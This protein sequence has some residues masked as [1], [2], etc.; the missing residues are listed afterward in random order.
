MSAFTF[1][2]L[3]PT[4]ADDARREAL[5][6]GRAVAVVEGG[7]GPYPVRCCLRDAE[8]GEGVLLLSAQPVTT[9]SPYAAPGPI[10]L[11]RDACEGYRA[12]GEVPEILRTRLL[13]VRAFDRAHMMIGTEVVQGADLEPVA[14]RLLAIPDTAYLHVHFA[15]A[16]CFACRIEPA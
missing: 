5:H 8:A 1:H 11:H 7:D 2:A 15:G 12:G 6:H 16:G 14:E 4:L 9:P 10:Y 3:P 13:S